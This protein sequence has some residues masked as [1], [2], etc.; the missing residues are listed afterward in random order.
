MTSDA[1]APDWSPTSRASK[2]KSDYRRDV[3]KQTAATARADKRGR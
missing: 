1:P 2:A 3:F